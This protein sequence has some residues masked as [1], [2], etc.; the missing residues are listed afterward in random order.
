MQFHINLWN[1]EIKLSFTG[2]AELHFVVQGMLEQRACW[3]G[4]LGVPRVLYVLCVCGVNQFKASKEPYT[5]SSGCPV[6]RVLE[7]CKIM[8]YTNTKKLPSPPLRPSDRGCSIIYELWLWLGLL[9]TVRRACPEKS[10]SGLGK[11]I[12]IC[13]DW[14]SCGM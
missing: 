14:V 8:P 7:L 9:N 6:S 11:V 10:H 1:W 13:A 5:I 12:N 2:Y 3:H 4:R